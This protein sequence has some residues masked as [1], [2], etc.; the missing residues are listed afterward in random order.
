MASKNPMTAE[1]SG[2]WR[3]PVQGMLRGLPAIEVPD[4]AVWDSLN[5]VVRKGF[6]QP[7][8]GLVRLSPT[9]LE[10]RPTGAINAIS[11]AEGAFQVDMVQDDAFQTAGDAPASNV[12]VG[13]TRGLWVFF[14]GLWHEITPGEFT[15]TEIQM[16]RFT[17][18]QI[19]DEIWV[20]HTNGI[21]APVQWASGNSVAS[22]IAGSPP[23]FADFTTIGDR[24]I[25]VIPPY[26][27][28]WGEETS[29]ASWPALNFKTLADT[30]DPIVA[31]RN[32]GTLG[33]VIYK[34]N[35]I[36]A[37]QFIGG[38]SASSYRF[39]L[40]GLWDGPASANAVVDA[41][42]VHYYCTIDGRIGRFDGL[43]HQWVNDGCWPKVDTEIETI[44]SKRIFG[45]YDRRN[46]ELRFY[47][48]V[49]GDRGELHGE[50]TV[51]TP[52]PQEG[53]TNHISFVGRLEHA[54][55]AGTE[56]RLDLNKTLLF[57]SESFLSYE[58]IEDKDDDGTP[59]SGYWQQ[60]LKGTPGLTLHR[61]EGVE[62]FAQRG[63]DYGFL[64][65]QVAHSNVLAVD[66]GELGPVKFVGLT[67]PHVFKELKGDDLRARFW[68]LRYNFTH[69]IQLRWQGG[70]LYSRL[71]ERV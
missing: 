8:P 45:V 60:G 27:I 41:D 66:G 18:I 19:D 68:G 53:V 16:S 2:Q 28:R 11:L 35:S 42:G 5:V 46:R 50:I 22:V 40:R 57:G 1:Q 69:P 67:D 9:N 15:A 32:L 26:E 48:P 17:S 21:D 62:T 61:L 29:L 51:I 23:K 71:V 12:L 13:T 54:V 55:S 49:K 39:E 30:P 34:T 38:T 65:L 31:I 47:Y 64:E 52:K 6:L 58:L 63:I 36:W 14:G 33:G 37:V 70:K 4:D 3:S 43:R 24:I 7:R 56:A 59:F 44:Y 20:L 25:G 10:A